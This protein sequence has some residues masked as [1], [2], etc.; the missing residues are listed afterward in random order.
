VVEEQS[1]GQDMVIAAPVR[2][3]MG[4]GLT[5]KDT[6]VDWLPTGRICFWGGFGGS[7][8]IMDLDR[9]LTICYV[10]NKLD[11]VGLGS[12]RTRAYVKAIYQG[13]GICLSC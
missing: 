13:L 1:M 12:N 5:G 2:F 11:S 7:I 8:I 10:M 9:R 4:F 6:F 3:G